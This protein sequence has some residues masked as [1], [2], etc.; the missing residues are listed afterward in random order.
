MNTE[1]FSFDLALDENLSAG[2]VEAQDHLTLKW[3]TLKSWHLHSEKG[4]ALMKRY[5]E[6]GA[7]LSGMAQ[8][9]S[10]EQKALICQMIDECN[11]PTI[12]LDWDGRNVSKDEAK[13]YVMEYAA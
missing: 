11:A 5:H 13:R 10:A 9:D 1:A 12:Y 3:G 2:P 6:L 4:Q 8:R 7:S